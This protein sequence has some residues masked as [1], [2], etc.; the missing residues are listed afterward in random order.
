MICMK[1]GNKCCLN[2]TEM[3][4]ANRASGIDL[5]EADLLSMHCLLIC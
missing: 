4:T 2:Q 1:E 5:L 3:K